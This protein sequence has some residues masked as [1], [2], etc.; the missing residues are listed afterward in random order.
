MGGGRGPG[1]QTTRSGR[2][3]RP[4]LK[5]VR[6]LLHVEGRPSACASVERATRLPGVFAA[7][8]VETYFGTRHGCSRR[9]PR[10]RSTFARAPGHGRP[11]AGAATYVLG[12][13]EPVPLALRTRANATV[14]VTGHRPGHGARCLVGSVVVPPWHHGR[15]R[16]ARRGGVARHDG[17][18]VPLCGGRRPRPGDSRSM[19]C[20]GNC[21]RRDPP[22]AAHAHRGAARWP[23]MVLTGQY[24]SGK[25]TLDEGAHGRRR[26]GLD[27]LGSRHVGRA[28]FRLGRPRRTGGYTRRTSRSGGS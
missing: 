18:L 28:G 21:L 27:R 16:T 15:D 24:S 11:G 5:T 23:R 9:R 13:T 12:L 4:R 22:A 17:P 8:Q 6:C 20:L 2:D 3:R 19:P 1:R 10:S 14:V 26:G 25:S 7:V